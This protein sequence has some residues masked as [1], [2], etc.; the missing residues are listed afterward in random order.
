[1]A[2]STKEKK[3]YLCH[4]VCLNMF[5]RFF[6]VQYVGST[7]G[8]NIE[9]STCVLCM[10]NM[11]CCT[12]TIEC[13]LKIDYDLQDKPFLGKCGGKGGNGLG[14]NNFNIITFIFSIKCI[15][16]RLIP[17]VLS[18]IFFD[19]DFNLPGLILSTGSG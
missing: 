1:M 3:T 8:I 9:T 14:K 12:S 10:I 4:A 11:I 6:I 15:S 18:A 17:E 13:N 19:Q 2:D 16:T 7:S 5:K